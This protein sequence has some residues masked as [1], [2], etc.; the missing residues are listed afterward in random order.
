MSNNHLGDEGIAALLDSAS[1]PRLVRADLA[2]NGASRAI[3]ELALAWPLDL[4]A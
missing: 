1:F 2:N 4:S 3:A